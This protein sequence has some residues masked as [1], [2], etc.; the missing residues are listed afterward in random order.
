MRVTWSV[1][2]QH[3]FV[4]AGHNYRG[5][6][7]K[8]A[9]A[10]P[11]EDRESIECVAGRGIRG[12]RYFDFRENFKGQATFFES[13]VHEAVMREF[14]LP[15]LSPWAFRRNIVLRGVPLQELIG[16][17]FS[18]QGLEFEGVE[19][20]APCYWMDEACADGVEEFLK[21]RGGLRARILTGG[22]LRRGPGVLERLAQGTAQGST[23]TP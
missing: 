20:A 3:L 1:E 4:S 12:D 7:G 21:G 17:R 18:L 19:E 2:V 5:R 13:E 16:R 22:W 15:E 10:H 11:V 8:G 9:L 6:H 23:T 14:Q